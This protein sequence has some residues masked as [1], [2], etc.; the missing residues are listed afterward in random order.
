MNKLTRVLNI[1]VTSEG[2]V[3]DVIDYDEDGN[4]NEELDLDQ[5]GWV[6]WQ[7]KPQD[8]IKWL[9]THLVTNSDM[10]DRVDIDV[11]GVGG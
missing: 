8:I 5:L 3:L 2:I 6:L 1:K 7:D 11:E 10:Y 4:F 9:K